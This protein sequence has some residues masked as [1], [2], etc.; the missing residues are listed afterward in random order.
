M[1]SAHDV[2]NTSPMDDNGRP[3]VLLEATTKPDTVFRPPTAKPDTIFSP[4]TTKPDNV[5][6]KVDIGPVLQ[7][8]V[9]TVFVF[10]RPQT[11][12][13]LLQLVDSGVESVSCPDCENTFNTAKDLSDVPGSCM[14]WKTYLT[15]L[16]TATDNCPQGSGQVEE[17][18]NFYSYISHNCTL[19]DAC[20]CQKA[21]WET[22]LTSTGNANCIAAKTRISCLRGKGGLACDNTT[23]VAGLAVAT[24]T[25]IGSFGACTIDPGS[26]CECEVNY[27]KA[28]V[29]SNSK[30]CTQTRQFISC[31]AGRPG[32]VCMATVAEAVADAE[33][34]ITNIPGN[35]CA[36][37]ESACAC[38][39]AYAKSNISDSNKLCSETKVY[40]GCL[41]EATGPGCNGT[42]IVQLIT[43]AETTLTGIPDSACA[44]NTTA[45]GCEVTYAK[46]DVSTQA[47]LCTETKAFVACLAGKIGTG[48]NT[49]VTV[50]TLIKQGETILL[51]IGAECNITGT[52]C[53][54]EI[55][56]AS[57][58]TSDDI[59]LC[60]E[61]KKFIGCLRGKTGTGCDGSSSVM[62]IATAARTILGTI[63][64]GDCSF[65]NTTCGCE[66]DFAMADISNN[67]KLCNATMAFISCLA[68]NSQTGCDGKT[69][70]G[71]LATSAEVAASAIGN[72]SFTAGS[73]CACE[74]NYTK[75]D[76]R[77]SSLKCKAL[78]DF[79]SCL[80]GKS[81]TGCDGSTTLRTLASNIDFSL[82]ALGQTEC[83]RKTNCECEAAFAMADISD[84]KRK[85][86]ETKKLTSCILGSVTSGCGS[87]SAKSS[88]GQIVESTFTDIGPKVCPLTSTCQ[89]EI[90]FNKADTSDSR[91]TCK[92]LAALLRCLEAVTETTDPVCDGSKLTEDLI[93]AS[94]SLHS[95]FC[96]L[97]VA[98]E[99]SILSCLLLTVASQLAVAH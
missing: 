35:I 73:V 78:Q 40:I 23:S 90:S 48:C 24:E 72:C 31:V 81:G 25:F 83:P 47:K 91:S 13:L 64:D 67:T 19:T 94:K 52:A 9:D 20:L 3:N 96:S 57:A 29:S 15:C 21:Y 98:K 1:S 36:V 84:T 61:T 27:V 71:Q 55:S 17:I 79:L 2:V 10:L 93:T 99:M 7:T 56:Y 18:G 12:T 82:T 32:K 97:G 26:A 33:T 85:C 44:L 76:I 14:A 58:N 51:G 11:G 66:A 92:S 75:A 37:S 43:E 46:A 70:V 68:G 69:S 60:R 59:K 63:T 86:T 34:T 88:I 45:C 8:R 77:T 80:V 39:I 53:A 28:D 95:V 5:S 4:S 22:H 54:C 42:A 50:D 6:F 65:T 62:Q 74:L 16:E 41:R 89:C 49:S 87:A 30:L 38:E